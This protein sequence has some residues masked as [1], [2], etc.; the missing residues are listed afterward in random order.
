MPDWNVPDAMEKSFVCNS[1]QLIKKNYCK[2]DT[3][4]NE[5]IQVPFFRFYEKKQEKQISCNDSKT[6]YLFQY[7]SWL[8]YIRKVQA[9]S[10]ENQENFLTLVVE[11]NI[12]TV[13]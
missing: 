6:L 10:R 9:N 4:K 7:D 2:N 8:G 11:Q 13:P 5:K 1:K 3:K 12:K